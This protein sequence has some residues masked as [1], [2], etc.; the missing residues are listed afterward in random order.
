MPSYAPL[1]IE[2]VAAALADFD[3]PPLAAPDT[4]ESADAPLVELTLAALMGEDD[5]APPVRL[6]ADRVGSLAN[7]A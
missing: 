6:P 4:Q 7:A 1:L 5:L 2:A 3:A